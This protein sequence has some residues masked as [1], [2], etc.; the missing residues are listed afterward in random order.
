MSSSIHFTRPPFHT[1]CLSDIVRRSRNVYF[2]KL[3]LIF[4]QFSHYLPYNGFYHNDMPGSDVVVCWFFDGNF[5][6]TNFQT[7]ERYRCR[8]GHGNC[9]IAR[10]RENEVG[11]IKE[12]AAKCLKQMFRME[13]GFLLV[14]FFKRT[15][16]EHFVCNIVEMTFAILND[17]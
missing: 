5:R 4:R 12:M 8:R 2:C 7:E 3:V 9:I 11:R 14:F 13:E 15:L 6:V 16:L 17:K 1:S 10:W